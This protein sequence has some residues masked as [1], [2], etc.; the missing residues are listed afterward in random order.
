[1]VSKDNISF[2]LHYCYVLPELGL[3]PLSYIDP[4]GKAEYENIVLIP[5]G[6]DN[7]EIKGKVTGIKICNSI[8]ECPYPPEK[9]KSIISIFNE[10]V[11]FKM[12]EKKELDIEDIEDTESKIPEIIEICRFYETILHTPEEPDYEDIEGKSLEIKNPFGKD[13]AFVDFEGYFSLYGCNAHTH[14]DAYTDIYEDLK[15]DLELFLN[16]KLASY[17]VTYNGE[18]L[19]AGFVRR[20]KYEHK[21]DLMHHIMR[22]LP[23]EFNKKCKK[24]SVKIEVN[25]WNPK[26][27]FIIE[28]APGEWGIDKLFLCKCCGH[29]FIKDEG[30][31]DICPVCGWEDD[32]IQNNDPDYWGGSNYFSLNKYRT[33]FESGADIHKAKEDHKVMV[34]GDKW[35]NFDY[36]PFLGY[37]HFLCDFELLTPKFI[38]LPLEF[39]PHKVDFR[40]KAIIPIKKNSVIELKIAGAK[41]ECD[42]ETGEDLYAVIFHDPIEKVGFGLRECISGIEYEK[43]NNGIRLKIGECNLKELEFIIAWKQGPFLI[44]DDLD[45]WFAIDPTSDF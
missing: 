3:H 11:E 21:N 44:K 42:L 8:S 45:V 22:F 16:N 17:Y 4:T 28:Y 10:P 29:V 36:K 19:C 34:T 27:D 24:S 12:F 40:K 25:F 5:Y 37:F 23:K 35:E 9:T 41:I 31:H 38:D 14:Y 2:P 13:S 7:K 30:M 43:L 1:M 33:V 18:W 39:G 26:D 6:K 20:D 15:N 32:D